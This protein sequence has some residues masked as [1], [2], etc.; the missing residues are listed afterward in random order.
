MEVQVLSS[1][2][3]KK[4]LIWRF[5]FLASGK[6]LEPIGENSL[7]GL[8]EVIKLGRVASGRLQDSQIASALGQ[9]SLAI[10]SVLRYYLTVVGC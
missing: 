2:P 5:F 9:S 3:R 1:A 6:R 10:I 7:E 4:N 8:F